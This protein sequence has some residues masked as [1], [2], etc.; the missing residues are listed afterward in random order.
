VLR[1]ESGRLAEAHEL[2]LKVFELHKLMGSRLHEAMH[3]C[4]F[5]RC[6]LRLGR[7]DEAKE[8]WLM[9]I[10]V[11]EEVGDVRMAERKRK[12]LAKLC[13]ELGIEPFA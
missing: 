12:S 2:Y 9:G 13:A 10:A 1:E 4:D 6:L 7:I 11:L 5:A 8:S 3:R